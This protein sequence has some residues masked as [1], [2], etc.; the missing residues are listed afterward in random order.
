MTPMAVDLDRVAAAREVAWAIGGRFDRKYWL[1]CMREGRF[2]DEMWEAMGEA[3]LLALSVP[4]DVGGAGGGMTELVAVMET[5]SGMGVPPFFLVITGLSRVPILKY[6][7]QE[8]VERYVKPTITGEKKLCF[9]ITEPEAGTN[10]FKIS[11]LATPT[12]NG[13]RLNGRK[14]FVTG[15][16]EADYM[17]VVTRTT[18][19][20]QVSDR[21]EGISLFV[22]D[23]KSEGIELQELNI[24]LNWPDKQFLVFFDDVELPE[25]SLV[26]EAGLG[27][28]YLF[29]ALNP[30]RLL[31]AALSI[32]L[33]DYALARAVNYARDRAPFGKPIGSYQGIQHPLARSKVN[34]EAA[35]LMTYDAA[36]KFDAG[37]KAGAQSNMAKL[38]ASEAG[39]AAI[40]VAIQTHGGNGFDSDYDIL[41]LL[42]GARLLEVAPISNEMVLNYIG[43]HVL[44][45]PKSY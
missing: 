11:T 33:G 30:E 19:A 43:E 18:R 44:G 1:Q 29:D 27:A 38:L 37:E 32:G 23:L 2:T 45:L 7:T 17:L 25:G 34:L 31:V 6:G 24:Q 15:A 16:N 39:V 12:D 14:V 22:V 40:D 41:P 4:E 26:G 10:T 13:Y 20:S 8:Q 5:L 36:A 9:G 35:R 28:R 21:R 3:G 42:P